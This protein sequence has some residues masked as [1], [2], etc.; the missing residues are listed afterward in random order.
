MPL[1]PIAMALAQFAPMI[2]GW[3][4]GSNAENVAAKVVGVAQAVT[5]TSTPDAAR[6]AIE[7]DPNLAMQ[8]QT[9]IVESQVEMAQIAADVT[10]AELAA[11]T[12]NTAA[13]NQTMQVEAKADHWP[14]YSWRPFVG[15]CFGFAWIGAYFFIPILRGWWPSIQ[16]PSIPPEAWV[17]I[18]GVLGVASFFRGK[19]QADPRVPADNRG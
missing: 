3:L 4:G 15:F 5:G 6:A 17:A 12:A 16:Q 1:I 14:T 13:V 10:K 7:A 9:K 8:F 11:D 18:G 2:A 19:M